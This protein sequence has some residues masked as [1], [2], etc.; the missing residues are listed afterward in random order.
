MCRQEG[1]LVEARARRSGD[2]AVETKS[3]FVPP[4]RCFLC[5]ELSP[6]PAT[7]LSSFPFEL[8]CPLP[9]ASHLI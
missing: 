7:P 8:E 6:P 5:L 2:K 9:A 3:M 4:S 1:L